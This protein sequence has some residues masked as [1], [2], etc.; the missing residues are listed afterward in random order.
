MPCELVA[1]FVRPALRALPRAAASRLG[2]CE[3]SLQASLPEDAASRW[4]ETQNALRVD[5]A[6]DRVDPHDAAMEL[7]TCIGQALWSVMAR[8]ERAAWLELLRREIDAAISGEIDERALEQKRNLFSNRAAASSG[9]ALDAYA[10]ESFAGTF[11]EYVHAMWHDVT[12]RSGPEHLPPE[13]LQRRL[14]L[15]ER[16]FPPN[17]G[18]RV[19]P[20]RPGRAGL[21]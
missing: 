6:T 4:I 8:F 1:E 9:A 7:L 14:A 19:F 16:W 15:M 18:Y 21:C 10:A 5:V 20:R 11:A 12:V 2:P 13:N 17:R 3:I